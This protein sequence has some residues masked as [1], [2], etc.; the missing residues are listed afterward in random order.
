[1]HGA[2]SPPRGVRLTEEEE[3]ARDYPIG[4]AAQGKREQ[5]EWS[6]EPRTPEQVRRIPVGGHRSPN[7]DI[8][9]VAER[10]QVTYRY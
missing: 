5:E 3:Y 2:V 10:G 6:S 9:P 4:G 1:M 8:S 7:E